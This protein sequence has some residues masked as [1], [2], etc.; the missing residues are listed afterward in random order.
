M[1]RATLQTHKTLGNEEAT[2][3]MERTMLP[4][5]TGFLLVLSTGLAT[6]ALMSAAG[7]ATGAELIGYLIAVSTA[8]A[9]GAQQRIGL[10]LGGEREERRLLTTGL[11]MIGIGYAAKWS[12]VP[13]LAHLVQPAWVIGMLCLFLGHARTW[14]WRG[15]DMPGRANALVLAAA[16]ALWGWVAQTPTFFVG[17]CAAMVLWTYAVV[18]ELLPDQFQG[19]WRL[20][21]PGAFTMALATIVRTHWHVI[22]LLVQH[23][24]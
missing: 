23:A 14:Q 10:G 8:V 3:T 19:V 20:L 1:V 5:V 17:G 24:L 7:Y 9:L 12:P 4:G 13:S 15:A 16:L 2:R 21:I 22:A 11:A 18:S 6:A